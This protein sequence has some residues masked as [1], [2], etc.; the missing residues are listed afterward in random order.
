MS[1]DSTFDNAQ[2]PLP[3]SA[4]PVMLP[5]SFAQEL[6]WLMHTS[7][8]ES[9]AYNVP[10]TRRLVGAVDVEALRRAFDRLIARHE[11]LRTTYA[12]HAE[13]AVQVVNPP[14]PVDLLFIDLRSLPQAEREAEAA[15]IALENARKPF[16]LARDQ[17]LRVAL[18]QLDEREHVLHIDS[19]HIA[20]DGWSRDILFRELSALYRE[21]LDG[22][23]AAL[24]DLPIQYA[25]Y[26][27][28]ER[29]HLAGD[30]L[31]MLL[32][33]WREQLG[34]AELVLELPTDFPRPVVPGVGGITERI[35]IEPALLDRVK[36][37]GRAHDATLYMTLL[38]AYAT[39]LHRYTG[40][41]DVLVGS[42]SA[43][44]S[45]AET[46][47]LIGYF[48]NTMVQRARFASDPTFAELL[49]QIRESALGAYDHQE[50]PFEKLVLEL[51]KGQQLSH[52]PLFQVV[53]TMLGGGGDGGPTHVGDAELAPFG[54]E[55]G[56]TKF[57][58][59]L[60]MS[61]RD[62]A[63]TLTLRARSD[64]YTA[65]SVK[66]T[67]G[68]LRAVL[69][70]A[71]RDAGV[72]VSRIELLSPVERAQIAEWNGTSANVGV[73]ATVTSLFE[74]QAARVPDRVAV[75][76]GDES[77][78]YAELD[79]RGNRLAQLLRSRGVES[80]TPVG[81]VLDRSVDLVA[82]LLG[83]LKAGGAYVPLPP[84]LPPVRVAQQLR[85]CG[86]RVVVTTSAH[87]D[88][89]PD[90]VAALCLDRDASAIAAT[91]A[92]APDVARD[93]AG[94]AYVLYTSGSTG[95][96]K[97]VA[98]T[99][100][101]VVHYARAISR[102]LADVPATAAG[103]GLR[104]LDGWTLGMVSTIGADLGN[105]AL[106]PALLA[107]ATL[108][109]LPRDV[110]TDP[111]RYAAYMASHPL[112][113]VKITPNHLRALTGTLASS[114]LAGALPRRWIVLG[115]EALG[116]DFAE[117]LLGAGS[118]RVL[119]HY[120][121]TETTVGVSTFE[122][123]AASARQAR[124][125]G[126]QTVP[127]GSPLAN[128]AL[129]LLDANREP[130]P[131]GLPGELYVTGSGVAQGYLH[132]D[133]LTAERFMT[134]EGLGRAYRTGDRTRRF[135]DGSIE[136]LGRA[137]DQVKI[138]GYRVELGEI[139]QALAEH[140][141]VAQAVAILQGAESPR[142]VAYVVARAAG[143]DYSLAHS[144]RL[145]AESLTDWAASR[146]PEYM[147]PTA[148]V[149]LERLPLSANGKID[150][151]ALPDPAESTAEASRHIAPRTETEEAIAAI[152]MDVLKQDSI[153]VT[154]DFIAL[155]GHSLL[156][157]RVLGRLSRKFGVRL[158]LRTLFDA[159]TVEQLSEIVD[160]ERQLAAIAS[161][162]EGE[163]G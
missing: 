142:L 14:R 60:F 73:P 99:H 23:P 8:P 11:I 16:D 54:V 137:D 143:S 111:V 85:E 90:G 78:T 151:A 74:A 71:V 152:W 129:H 102:V 92:T 97:G 38:G 121:P 160:L 46:E 68:H 76:S 17:I 100:A 95:V 37:L 113:V 51:Q 80:N 29:E 148:I 130:V 28:F 140:P 5:T 48:A 82:A 103:D 53:F 107:G 9:T 105:T 47:G 162:T 35:T 10:R 15:R 81:L 136:F 40:Q 88:R 154:D 134:L 149:L 135:E 72:R 66:R 131:V 50:I 122:V 93:P 116:W 22:T 120:G 67:L 155:G 43:G 69:E 132:R 110:T 33:Y 127:I 6:L 56:T 65:A 31:E 115:G 44:R 79:A 61:E 4:E 18:L 75:V 112:D 124:S 163:S 125:A 86:A 84:E 20:F 156:A 128:V 126:A 138:R 147:V 49:D 36:A 58:L 83:V 114:E 55:D 106:F 153:S 19:H 24:P 161:L 98:V 145:T 25:D 87:L 144:G 94:L 146:L 41:R 1:L 157:I 59:T 2:A 26:A 27:I 104:A 57:D 77:L 13:H 139:E 118:C 7:A 150:R 3:E 96:P 30:R 52:S 63:L 21:A 32:A 39:V 119:N 34:D 159:P 158:P 89:V 12:F 45:R 108:H 70:A 91:T 62:G 101:N 123:T 109:L 117:R 133:D 42:P 64:L 141:A